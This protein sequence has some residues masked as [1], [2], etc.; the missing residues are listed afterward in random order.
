MESMITYYNET[1]IMV[2]DVIDSILRSQESRNLK[3]KEKTII[4]KKNKK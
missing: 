3:I 4:Q 1:K 2:H